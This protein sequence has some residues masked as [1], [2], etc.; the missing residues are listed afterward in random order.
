MA[1]SIKLVTLLN[2][3]SSNLIYKDVLFIIFYWNYFNRSPLSN[4]SDRIIDVTKHLDKLV[5]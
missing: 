5:K 3:N 1:I 4:S 2:V